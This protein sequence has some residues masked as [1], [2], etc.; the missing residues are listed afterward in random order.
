MYMTPVL[1]MLLTI[2]FSFKKK[3]L[4]KTIKPYAG[5]TRLREREKERG[6][7][8]GRGRGRG[9]MRGRLKVK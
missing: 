6:G 7:G 3:K 9:R 4:D 8:R 2:A 1:L 5:N